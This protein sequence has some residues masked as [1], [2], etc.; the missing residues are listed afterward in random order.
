[1]VTHEIRI[2]RAAGG[3]VHGFCRRLRQARG[4]PQWRAAAP[5]ATRQVVVKVPAMHCSSCV[6]TIRAALRTVDG[7]KSSQF[8][9]EKK[10]V[11]I[12]V[13]APQA[14]A[15]AVEEAITAAITGA[16]F[17]VEKAP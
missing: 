14:G 1:M 10:L 13:V 4:Q 17:E 16:D 5:A 9:L 2:P 3:V 15:P 12:E 6:G 8:D 7:V 11:T